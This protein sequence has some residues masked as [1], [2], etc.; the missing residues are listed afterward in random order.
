MKSYLLLI[1]ISFA[2]LVSC[3][4]KKTEDGSGAALNPVEE[5]ELISKAKNLFGVLPD[6]MPGSE[7]DTPELISLGKK[8]YSETKLSLE[9]NQSCAT[10]HMLDGKA[11]VDNKPTSGGSVKDKLGTRNSPTVLNAGFQFAQFWDARAKDL[12]EQAKGPILNPSE[13][14][15]KSE[16]EVV[17]VI[18]EIPEYKEMFDKAFPTEKEK[19]SYNNIAVAIA[20]FE[21]TLISKARYDKYMAGDAKALTNDEK[22]GLK[23]FIESGCI[24]CHTGYLFGGT[25]VQK[26]GLIKPYENT[27]DMGKYD[28]TKVE[29]DKYM[30]KVA[31]LRNVALTA[32]YFHDGKVASLEDAVKMMGQMNLGKEFKPE[33]LTLLVKFLKALSDEKLETTVATK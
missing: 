23:L 24:T 16:K 32:P 12:V 15:M 17:K 31:Q 26:M 3:G 2:V 9:N 8:L 11:G 30:F 28:L 20:A 5:N 33:E 25:M 22:R 1:A 27:T 7:K 13:M 29:S 21:R 18:A 6:K 4:Q 14:A 10:C 19:V